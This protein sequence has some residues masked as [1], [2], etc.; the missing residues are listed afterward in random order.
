MSSEV[1]VFR[2]EGR[3]LIAHDTLPTWQKF[4]KDVRALKPEHAIEK[5]Y[6]L[7]G[8]KHKLKRKHIKIERVYEIPPEESK[9]PS[10]IA[11]SKITYI[12]KM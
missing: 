10:I 6:S 3:M 9:D 12:V 8:S 11:L 7:L 5:V 1:K 2:V 4:V